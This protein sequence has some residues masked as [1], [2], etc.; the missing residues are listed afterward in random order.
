MVFIWNRRLIRNEHFI[1]NNKELIPDLKISQSGL[2]N[3]SQILVIET[4]HLIGA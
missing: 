4:G 2:E 3:M 1:F